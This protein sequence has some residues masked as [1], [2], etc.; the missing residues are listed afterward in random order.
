MKVIC[1]G[2]GAASYFFAA[3]LSAKFPGAEITI[4]EQ[5][6]NVLGK[7]AISGGGRCNVTHHCYDPASLVT[8]Y[9]RGGEALLPAFR[10][11]G[12]RNTVEW[13]ESRG[14]P[15]K[16][17]NDGRIFPVSN[18]SSSI[19]DCLTKL[20]SRHGVKTLTGMKVTN[21][22]A[23]SDVGFSV[24]TLSGHR[25]N[26]DILF[27]A[28]GGSKP[29]WQILQHMGYH[30]VK[31]VPSLFTFRISDPR[32]SGLAGVSVS[33]VKITVPGTELAST[34]PLLITHKGLSGPAVLK[35]SSWG[36]HYFNECNYNFD[37]LVDFVPDV[38]LDDIKSWRDKEGKRMLG[39]HQLSGLP[40]RLYQS[41]LRNTDL[42][43]NRKLATLS[44][45]DLEHTGELLKQARFRVVGQNTYKEEFVT[46]GGV[47][48]GNV[49]LNSFESK[50]HRNLYMAGEVLNIDAVTGGFNFQAA[51][52][53]AF[54]AAADIVRKYK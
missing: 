3:N 31:P 2:G 41:L 52:T 19:T 32:I 34:G 12:P 22:K 37:L 33:D 7:V 4:L 40:R 43:T 38:T 54:L 39:N 42:D 44:N 45:A 5:G 28:P 13:F 11:F 29:V 50:L 21:I 46:A 15:L 36:A 51:W 10:Q 9:P 16:T 1:I 49:D 18:S 14:V 24:D 27:V 35:L 8:Y 25:L 48:L 23:G 53:G 20:V 6:R 47:D 26:A 17:E 30:I